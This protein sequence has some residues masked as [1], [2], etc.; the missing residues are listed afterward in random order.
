M[1]S[2]QDSRENSVLK[3]PFE[4]TPRLTTLVLCSRNKAKWQ[5]ILCLGI[6][7]FIF[8]LQL[9]LC[10]WIFLSLVLKAQREEGVILICKPRKPNKQAKRGRK[11]TRQV[12]EELYEQEWVCFESECVLRVKECSL[13]HY[14]LFVVNFLNKSLF[15]WS[16]CLFLMCQFLQ[17]RCVLKWF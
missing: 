5:N 16:E 8:P 14:P 15:L 3:S 2:I 10:I 9:Y 1:F 4:C 11:K 6:F 17:D 7:F 12:S 13:Q